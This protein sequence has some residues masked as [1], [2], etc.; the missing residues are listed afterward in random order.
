MS[1]RPRH[2]AGIAPRRAAQRRIGRYDKWLVEFEREAMAV[3]ILQLAIA[4]AAP[5]LT[6]DQRIVKGY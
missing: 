1:V 6:Y 2:A 5:H 3:G 4:A